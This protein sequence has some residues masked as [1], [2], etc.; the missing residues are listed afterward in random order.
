M[1]KVHHERRAAERR[2]FVDLENHL[3]FEMLIS[4]LSTKFINLR[5]D[6]IDRGIEDALR[7]LCKCLGID[8]AVLWQW[9]L[10]DPK[11]VT[12]TH[13][14]VEEGLPDIGPVFQ[15]Y[16]P[17]CVEEMR[18]GRMVVFSSLDEL[19][20]AANVDREN[21]RLA[22]VKSNL[23][24]PL[25]LGGGSTIGAL[26]LSSVR[27]ERDWPEAL[28]RRLQLVAQAFTN[29]LE[30]RRLEVSRQVSALRL[31]VGAELAGLAFYE[32]DF[33]QGVTVY[34]DD[35][36]RDLCGVPVNCD[37]LAF[38]NKQLHPDD[39]ERVLDQRRQMDEGR[40]EQFTT[41]YRFLHPTQG[42]KWLEH[43]ACVSKRNA[44]GQVLHSH[45]VLRDVTAQKRVEH[46]MREL[47]RRLIQAQEKERAMLARELHDD[48]TQ[49]LAVLAIEAGRAELAAQDAAQAAAMQAIREG[50]T[51]LSEDIHD[52][53]YQLHPSILLELGLVEALRAE[54]ERRLRQASFE[55]AADLDPLPIAVGRDAQLCLF[56]V[57]QEALHNVARHA[58]AGAASVT[59]R[60]QDGGLLLA[61]RDDGVGFDVP[62]VP[63]R[64]R[65]GLVSMRER[66]Q[67]V[68]GT[69]E[70]DSAPGKGTTVVAWVPAEEGSP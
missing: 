56:R 6:D 36:F 29:L 16:F 55:L 31:V 19:P 41:E 7:L 9:S 12:L 3:E 62:D 2:I 46:E 52:M 63:G 37:I 54:C 53:A 30:R 68:R 43:V 4:E 45:G 64:R 22:G 32:V 17:W 33:S 26:G 60:N 47:S 48:V 14:Y 38:W 13:A 65:L 15:E 42:E 67:L 25:A 69:F 44:I 35:R 49:R 1:S 57:A 34:A 66:V 51:S 70:V 24:L 59:L 20:A 10:A 40:M 39:R 11:V 27:A 18:G 61:V 28:I 23:C 50:L 21:C 5:S 58:H 8:I